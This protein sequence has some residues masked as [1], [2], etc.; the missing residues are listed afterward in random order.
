MFIVPTAQLIPLLAD[1]GKIGTRYAVICTAGF[2]E[3]GAEGDKLEKELKETAEKY[4][5]RFLGP[6]C[7]GLINSNLPLNITV[8]TFDLKPG[9]LGGM[10]SQSGTYITRRLHI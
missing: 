3:V 5:I 8:M 6:N 9:L 10:A 4:G 7:I 1:F 2:R